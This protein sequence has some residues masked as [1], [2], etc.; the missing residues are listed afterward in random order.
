MKERSITIRTT[1]D[2]VEKIKY[3]KL[4]YNMN[5]SEILRLLI[6]NEYEKLKSLKEYTNKI[7]KGE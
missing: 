2:I 1:E 6:E 4:E 3:I 5:Q 7:N